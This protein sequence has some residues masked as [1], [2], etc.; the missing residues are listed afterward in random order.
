MS[1][2]VARFSLLFQLDSESTIWV[3]TN[4]MPKVVYS[5]LDFTANNFYMLKVS[6]SDAIRGTH[7]EERFSARFGDDD[8]NDIRSPFDW[9]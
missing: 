2:T 8:F 5:K 1:F 3:L 6:V 4:K 7:C 9:S